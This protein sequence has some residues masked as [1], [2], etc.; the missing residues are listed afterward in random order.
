[1]LLGEAHRLRLWGAYARVGDLDPERAR[2]EN[3]SQSAGRLGV[4]D[5]IRGQ[6]ACDEESIVE[7]VVK[8][9]LL[10]LH[11]DESSC[12]CGA[13]GC[14]VQLQGGLRVVPLSDRLQE[15]R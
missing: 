2:T 5:R 15:V 8:V 14:P 9:P 13:A 4:Q 11:G 12:R 7:K 6:L 3:Q 1:M 10:E